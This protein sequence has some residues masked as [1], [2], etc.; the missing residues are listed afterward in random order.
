MSAISRIAT[1]ALLGASLASAP[2]I[3]E[4]WIGARVTGSGEDTT[5]SYSATNTNNI[6]GGALVRSH[7]SGESAWTEVLSAP[8]L[9][10]SRPV[11]VTGNGVDTTLS[12]DAAPAPATPR[13]ARAAPR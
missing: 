7:G 9:Q 8:N 10:A 6:V 3:A 2:A 11:R 12:Y 4:E 1:A 13:M 5:L